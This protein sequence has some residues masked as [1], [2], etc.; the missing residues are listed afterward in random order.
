MGLTDEDRALLQQAQQQ[1]L[2]LS[3]VPY[4]WW[5]AVAYP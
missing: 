1:S 4:N 5:L 3:V 2:L